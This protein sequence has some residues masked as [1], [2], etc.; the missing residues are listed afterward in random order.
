M[1]R[2]IFGT[3]GIMRTH[4]LFGEKKMVLWWVSFGE[5]IV[6]EKVFIGISIQIC[7]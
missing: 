1:V 6:N 4:G 7:G 5:L 3:F 2:T